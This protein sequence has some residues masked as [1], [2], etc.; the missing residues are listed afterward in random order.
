MGSIGRMTEFNPY[1]EE[2]G[3]KF[4]RLKHYFKANDVKEEKQVSILI[5][6]IGPKII[7]VLSDILSPK[8]ADEKIFKEVSDILIG[9]YSPKQNVLW[10]QRDF[11]FIADVKNQQKLFQSSW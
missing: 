11:Y 3:L 5:T 6:A 10:L 4:L 2:I 7:S 9:H 8:K 1:E